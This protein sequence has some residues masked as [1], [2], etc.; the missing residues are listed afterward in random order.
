VLG[1]GVAVV[2]GGVAVPAGGTAAPGVEACP[3]VLA[4]VGAG[5]AVPARLLW[6][7]I[8][9]PPLTRTNNIIIRIDMRTSALEI[10]VAA[11]NFGPQ[12]FLLIS[13]KLLWK[14]RYPVD[15]VAEVEILQLGR[16]L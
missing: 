16:G 7:I 14:A 8:Q 10:A 3:G 2:V 6:A 9:L 5:V 11:I 15:T 4:V 13:L 1:G 12:T